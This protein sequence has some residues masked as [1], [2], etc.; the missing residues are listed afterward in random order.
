MKKQDDFFKTQFRIPA[1]VY[2]EIK[3]LAEEE[4]RSIN[5]QI[6]HLLRVAL[7]QINPPISEERMKEIMRESVREELG[8][9]VVK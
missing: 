4:D 9:K 8:N 7:E 2:A 5:G 6:I 1:D 3:D